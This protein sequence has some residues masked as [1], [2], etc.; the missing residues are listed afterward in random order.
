MVSFNFLLE[1]SNY[2]NECFADAPAIPH[3]YW[4]EGP[5]TASLKDTPYESDTP[6]P[7]PTL[8][9]TP[10]EPCDT[11]VAT[12]TP[13]HT[14]EPD[15]CESETAISYPMPTSDSGYDSPGLPTPSDGYAVYT[16]SYEAYPPPLR[17]SSTLE[18]PPVPSITFVYS[19]IQSSSIPEYTPEPSL[20]TSIPVYS[21]VVSQP[22][23]SRSAVVPSQQNSIGYKTPALT[24]YLARSSLTPPSGTVIIP[25]SPSVVS[26]SIS[27]PVPS[28]AI[29]SILP[30]PTTGVASV[31]ASP[32]SSVGSDSTSLL[33]PSPSNTEALSTVQVT[34]SLPLQASSMITLLISDPSPISSVSTPASSLRASTAQSSSIFITYSSVRV[35]ISTTA[36]PSSSPTTQGTGIPPAPSAGGS[37]GGIGRGKERVWW[38]TFLIPFLFAL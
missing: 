31:I 21:F 9:P 2:S 13:I 16:S 27:T 24:S 38:V 37:P 26:N 20:P 36:A 23:G 30:G 28:G 8:P 4:W 29:S 33:I 35:T 1:P 32:E 22:L 6:F 18:V 10:E 17:P 11:E 19:P 3:P 14:S 15:P 7:L 12:A 25:V 5:Y 34:S